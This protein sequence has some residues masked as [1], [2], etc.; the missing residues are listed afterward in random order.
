MGV[1]Y[2]AN[3]GIGYEVGESYAISEEELE[4]GLY[5]YLGENVGEDFEYF[6]T[7][8]DY[9]GYNITYYLTIKDPFKDGLDLT[10]KKEEL[11]KE[12]KRLKLETLSSFREVGG[13]HVW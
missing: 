4:E 2:D 9:S 13:L 1:D 5:E 7:G 8:N 12:I 11:D 6:K 10:P 3:F